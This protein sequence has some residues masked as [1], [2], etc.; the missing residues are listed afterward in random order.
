MAI[1]LEQAHRLCRPSRWSRCLLPEGVEHDASVQ[2]RADVDGCA[3]LEKPTAPSL[4][5]AT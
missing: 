4:N 1:V 5:E 3:Y 2:M